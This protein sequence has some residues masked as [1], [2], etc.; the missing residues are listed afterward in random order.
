MGEERLESRCADDL[1]V[2]TWETGLNQ[3][4]PPYFW[5]RYFSSEPWLASVDY[6]ERLSVSLQGGWVLE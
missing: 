5:T 3:I 1:S 2:Q 6:G 4:S